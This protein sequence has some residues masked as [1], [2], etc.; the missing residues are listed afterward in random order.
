MSKGRAEVE[1]VFDD[2]ISP[3]TKQD[4]SHIYLFLNSGSFDAAY[5][6]NSLELIEP[7]VNLNVA[8]FFVIVAKFLQWAKH[9][10]S[11]DLSASPTSF[12][13]VN[14]SSLLAVL[15]LN[16]CSL[17]CAGKAY[18]EAVMAVTA[19]ET[20]QS[21]QDFKCVSWAPGP[22]ET[23]MMQHLRSSDVV[24]LKA[25]TAKPAEFYICPSRSACLLWRV[26]KEDAFKSGERIDAFDISEPPEQTY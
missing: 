24:E 5:I 17:Y 19:L 21:L 14:I 26:L 6:T 13:L 11:R 25:I 10:G 20:K 2:A 12:R 9:Y 15:P 1:A 7:S 23:K 3:L 22:M 18:R 4:F 16:G 8:S